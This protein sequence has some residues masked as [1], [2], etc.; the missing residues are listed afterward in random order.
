MVNEMIE[1]TKMHGAGNDYIYVNTM[2]YDI[3]DPSATA[4]AWS[5]P[6]FGIGS[7]GL[8]LIGRS[9]TP[10]ADFSMRIFN[11]DGSEAM[12]CGNGT[13]CVAKYLHDKGLTDKNPIR[14]E[15]LSGIKILTLHFDKEGR[16]E[17]VTVDMG[18]P[19][20]EDETQF[21]PVLGKNLSTPLPCREGQGGGSSIFVSMG[22]PHFV[23]FTD[24]D[25]EKLPIEVYGPQ[26]E[27]HPAFPQRC[28]IEFAQL[29]ADGTVRMRVWE[30]GSGITLA[31]GT[32]ACATA[33]AAAITGRT[34]RRC[35]IEMDGGVL[36]IEWDEAT[37]HV[38]KTGPA[39]IVFEGTINLF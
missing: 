17:T 18:A 19:I 6:H 1:F 32:G 5:R 16:V 26:L 34:G 12:M 27:H 15:T 3:P 2:K 21:D 24:E 33:V 29:R 11:N 28:N 9:S 31:C 39:A 13:R 10:D 7:D 4:I 35:T 14:L 8:I 30:R 23:I 25:V 36:Q 20:L 22:N 38:L 37:N